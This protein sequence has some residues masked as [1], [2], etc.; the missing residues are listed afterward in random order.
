MQT[1]EGD[2][3]RLALVR[4]ITLSGKRPLI[5]STGGVGTIRYGQ[6]GECP[7]RRRLPH[8]RTGARNRPRN[9]PRWPKT[10]RS[11]RKPSGIGR[12]TDFTAGP[13]S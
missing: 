9:R 13:I 8:G 2:V 4:E 12:A 7:G 11:H 6:K 1:S 5:K 10:R 3:R